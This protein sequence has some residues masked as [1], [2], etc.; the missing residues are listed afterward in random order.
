MAVDIHIKIDTIPG[1]SVVKGF[2][3]QIQ[4]ESFSWGMSQTTNFAVSG[5]GTAGKVSMKDFNFTHLVDKA[6]PKL[7][8]ACCKGPRCPPWRPRPARPRTSR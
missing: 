1:M 4:I 2:E 6:T 5:G 3:D 8:A 7:M